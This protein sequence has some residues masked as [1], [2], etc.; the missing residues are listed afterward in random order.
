MYDLN[1]ASK[2]FLFRLS[3]RSYT[4]LFF[5]HFI[6]LN[7]MPKVSAKTARMK[8]LAKASAAAARARSVSKETNSNAAPGTT[9]N[10]NSFE[11]SAVNVTEEGTSMEIISWSSKAEKAAERFSRAGPY[12]DRHQRRLK[13]RNKE[14]ARGS[15][16]ILN[17]FSP[18]SRPAANEQ[19]ESESINEKEATRLSDPVYI[20]KLQK[21][22][23]DLGKFA[24]PVANRDSKQQ[25]M[26]AF[27]L[28]KYEGVYH[29]F[30]M[31]VEKK[32]NKMTASRIASEIIYKDMATE[33][34]A[35]KSESMQKSTF[36]MVPSQR[37]PNK[38]L[39][40]N[41]YLYLTMKISRMI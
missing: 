9:N 19:S 17:F 6:E 37:M 4:I 20:R 39:I 41:V 38:V 10:T 18:T 5:I 30:Y 28:A 13:Q 24:V 35:K 14:N 22:L 23:E 26:G 7:P 40:Q 3:T 31:I 21:A 2:V 29:Y 11:I 33:Y 25:Q 8:A 1:G 27:E 15:L 32:C 36:L 34:R 16:S 12:S